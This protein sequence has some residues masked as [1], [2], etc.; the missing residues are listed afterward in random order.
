MGFRK[1]GLAG[2]I[3]Q[4]NAVGIMPVNEML[5]RYDA[6]VQVAVGVVWHLCV[7]QCRKNIACLG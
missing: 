6:P 7:F 5:R 2:N 1:A 3:V 4:L